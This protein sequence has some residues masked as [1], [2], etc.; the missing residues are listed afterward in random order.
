MSKL[1]ADSSAL[2][3]L[4]IVDIDGSDPLSLCFGRYEVVVPR[5]VIEEF[6]CLVR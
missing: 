4:G 5:A 3:S 2:V 1:V 6:H